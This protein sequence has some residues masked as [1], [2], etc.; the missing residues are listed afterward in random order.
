M[1]PSLKACTQTPRQMH[2]HVLKYIIA[3]DTPFYSTKFKPCTFSH[4]KVILPYVN[5][6][7]YPLAGLKCI[8]EIYC[9]G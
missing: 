3:L 5:S 2:R 8:P 9:I 7:V 4:S 1:Y 6:T